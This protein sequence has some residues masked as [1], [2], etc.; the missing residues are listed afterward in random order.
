M[1][2]SFTSAFSWPQIIWIC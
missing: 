1:L 2:V